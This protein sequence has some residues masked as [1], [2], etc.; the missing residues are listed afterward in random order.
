MDRVTEWITYYELQERKKKMIDKCKFGHNFEETSRE[1]DWDGNTIYMN[2]EGYCRTCGKR[3]AMVEHYK[4]DY[5]ETW[6]V[7][8]D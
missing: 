2:Y 3:L 4:M 5:W 1:M 6:E 8:D 7:K